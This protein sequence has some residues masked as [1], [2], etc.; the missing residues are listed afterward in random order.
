[1]TKNLAS[2]KDALDM[3]TLVLINPVDKRRTGFSQDQ[4]SKFPPLA[5]GVV[6]ALT[7]SNWKV[8]IIDENFKEARFIKADLVGITSYTENVARAY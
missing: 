6:A 5:L 4:V 7:P 3:K 8:K 2:S 1:M